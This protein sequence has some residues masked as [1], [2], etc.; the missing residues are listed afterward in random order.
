MILFFIAI[1]NLIGKEKQAKKLLELVLEQC[2]TGLSEEEWQRQ[3]DCSKQCG[4]YFVVI[5]ELEWTLKNMK[6]P[7]YKANDLFS[8]EDSPEKQHG[9]SKIRNDN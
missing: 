5:R 4:T 8:K 2:N 6:K 3:I 9:Y 1:E 7:Y